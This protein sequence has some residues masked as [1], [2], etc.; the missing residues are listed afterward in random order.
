MD[1]E[2]YNALLKVIDYLYDNEQR[3]WEE[4]GRPANH[5]FKSLEQLAGWSQEVA[6][7]YTE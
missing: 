4:S 1:E 6:K 2:T 3:H 5:I 7:E